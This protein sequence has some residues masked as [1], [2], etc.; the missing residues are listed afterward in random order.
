MEKIKQITI[1][2]QRWQAAMLLAVLALLLSY[3]LAA[4]CPE[5]KGAIQLFHML[6][7]LAAGLAGTVVFVCALVE[8]W[9]KWDG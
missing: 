2:V 8:M 6:G 7:M 4:T 9:D 1:K 3:I 5:H